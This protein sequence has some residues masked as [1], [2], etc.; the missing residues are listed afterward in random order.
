MNL[1][2]RVKYIV[3]H[4]KKIGAF[5]TLNYFIQ[6][7]TVAKNVLIKVTVPGL[8]SPVLLRNKT[9][10]INIFYQIFIAEELLFDFKGD[11][12]TIMD[13]GAN[14]GL[15]TLY[16]RRK[17]P[18]AKIIS[19]EPENNNYALL[20]KNTGGYSDII[21]INTGV[22][23]SDCNL[24]LVDIGEGEASYR[25]MESAGHYKVIDNISCRGI[26][27]LVNEYNLTGINILKMDIEGSEYAC[28]FSSQIDWLKKT[29]YLLIEIHENMHPGMTNDIHKILPSGSTVSYNGEYT[30][31]TNDIFFT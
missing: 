8:L 11:I 30:I 26:D 1:L 20:Q 23:G 2:S 16:F 6:R 19:I 21:C 25:V 27:S 31:I 3:K 18:A 13:C 9:Y 24:V 15:S 12:N 29:N 17:F 28:M 4:I 14:I 7:I 10:D 5:A 22:Y